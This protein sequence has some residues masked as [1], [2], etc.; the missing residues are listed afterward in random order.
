MAGTRRTKTRRTRRTKKR[1]YRWVLADRR[2]GAGTGKRDGVELYV[3][4]ERHLHVVMD[5]Y[6][7]SHDEH[8]IKHAFSDDAEMP[9]KRR[10][11]PLQVN[12]LPCRSSFHALLHG[13]P[14]CFDYSLSDVPAVTL[15]TVAME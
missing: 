3:R 13:P 7:F 1:T 8:A 2:H 9:D 4:S 11:F 15:R 6:Q 10:C 5:R 14:S 12:P